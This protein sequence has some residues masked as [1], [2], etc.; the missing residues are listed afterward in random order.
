MGSPDE[1][2]DEPV[3]MFV[4]DFIGA[5][6]INFLHGQVDRDAGS[7]LHVGNEKIPLAV[8]SK[9]IP[10]QDITLGIRPLDI[11]VD[12][13]GNYKGAVEFVENTG[14]ETHIHVKFANQTI[15]LV[16]PTRLHCKRGEAIPFHID[17]A[18]VHLF[19]RKTENRILPK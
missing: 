1:I 7:E 19:D 2:Y 11:K 14:A 12:S 5:P 6:T 8:A 15:R 10:S 9:V 13:E 18:K 16:S 17:P 4:A 3:N